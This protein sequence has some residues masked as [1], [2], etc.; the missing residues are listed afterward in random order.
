MDNR[1]KYLDVMCFPGLFPNGHFGEFHPRE[2][3][4]LSQYIKSRL[5]NK[6]SRFR[7]KWTIRILSALAK[8][9]A[10]AF[11]RCVQSVEIYA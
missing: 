8:R 4:S 5:L 9:N 10:R 1:Q 2:E 6:D 7:K 11:S 3:K